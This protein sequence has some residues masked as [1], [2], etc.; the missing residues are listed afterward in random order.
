MVNF[1][2]QSSKA[3]PP[4]KSGPS[5]PLSWPPQLLYKWAVT[6]DKPSQFNKTCGGVYWGKGSIH[7]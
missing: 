3:R 2:S 7:Q 5:F 4:G 6:L 1:P